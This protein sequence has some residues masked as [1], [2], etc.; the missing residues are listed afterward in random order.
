MQVDAICGRVGIEPVPYVLHGSDIQAE[1]VVSIEDHSLTNT[2][3]NGKIGE[4][5]ADQAPHVCVSV[6]SV[7]R[8]MLMPL[9]VLYAGSQQ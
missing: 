9:A 6:K 4:K 1:L 8:T 3:R 5:T 7:D 2:C